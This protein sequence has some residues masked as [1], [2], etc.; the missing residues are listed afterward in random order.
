M[1]PAAD[2]RTQQQTK[3][4]GRRH[5]PDGAL[6]LAAAY[7]VMEQQL[8]CGGPQDARNSVNDEQSHRMPHLKR[9][10]EKQHAPADRDQHEQSHAKLNDPAGVE[11]VGEGAGV[12]HG[13]K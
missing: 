4:P 7:H 11:P 5:G 6:Q 2:C 13:G 10:G 1:A 9:I 8:A 12:T 3:G